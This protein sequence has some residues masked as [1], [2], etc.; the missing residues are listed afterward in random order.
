[1]T[2]EVRTYDGSG[3]NIAHPTWGKANEPLRRL[4]PPA[5]T[6]GINDP[7][8]TPGANPRA[9]SNILCAETRALPSLAG[10]SDFMW[11]W[12]QFLD[13]EIDLSPEFH[14]PGAPTLAIDIPADDPV[15][16]GGQ[17]EIT[18]SETHVPPGQSWQQL[19]VLS[20]YIDGS[21]VYGADQARADA[22]REM[23]GGR[24]KTSGT[25]LLPRNTLG[26][27]NAPR[28]ADPR[29]FA[30]G[31][32]RA[33]EHAVLTSM[34]TLFMREHNRRCVQILASHPGLPS[35][36]ADQDEEV[37][38]QARRHVY[39][40]MQVI[41]YQ[42]FLP[43]LLGAGALPDYA[44]YRADVDATISNLFSTAC[45]R[46]GHSMLSDSLLLADGSRMMLRD[47]FFTPELVADNGIDLFLGGLAKQMMR[48]VDMQIIDSVRNFL[49]QRPGQGNT[50]GDLATRNILRGRDHGLPDYN[51][52][53]QALG[54]PALSGFADVSRR[55]GVVHGLKT[56][57]AS[58]NDIDPWI[59]GLAEDHLPGAAVGPFIHAVLRE[60]FIRLRDG[61]RFWYENDPALAEDLINVGETLR[62]LKST[63]LSDVIMR[64]T[65]LRGLPRS[66]FQAS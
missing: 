2:R 60:Q 40:L 27:G 6:D 42:E 18:R 48:E 47:A 62:D 59:G 29:Y 17:V 49:F 7:P 36:P 31:D 34:H 57:Y 30:A 14:G 46:L 55:E 13:H 39:A 41:T 32:V 50:L 3:N 28:D 12:G 51:T 43:A 44:G 26:L 24:L 64:N 37:Y 25:D 54:L 38:Q 22:L 1:M 66:V 45:Y 53:R 58:V 8:R 5:Y 9:V 63:T 21:N 23:S 33:N 16:P 10:L 19:N 35:S 11:A 65:G 4:A 61:D 56:A 52:C 20:S 15:L